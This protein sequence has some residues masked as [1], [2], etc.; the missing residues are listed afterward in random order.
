[1][2]RAVEILE[3]VTTEYFTIGQMIK[4]LE[5]HNYSR[6]EAE[7]AI[8][9]YSNKH[10]VPNYNEKYGCLNEINLHSLNTEK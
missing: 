7:E 2:D 6:K 1:M 9:R 4:L 5:S 8:R 3:N 10:I